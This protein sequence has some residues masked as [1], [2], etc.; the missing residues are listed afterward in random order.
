MS[1][2]CSDGSIKRA[3]LGNLSP[4]DLASKVNQEYSFDAWLQNTGTDTPTSAL[5][6]PSQVNDA[7]FSSFIVTH[8]TGRPI[9]CPE[10]SDKL[11]LK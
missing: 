2:A 1:P 3:A 10:V 9:F 6:Y 11:C 5:E 4:V 8:D 7:C